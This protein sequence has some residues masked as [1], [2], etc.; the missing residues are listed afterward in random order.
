MFWKK[1]LIFFRKKIET[2]N[3]FLEFLVKI[4]SLLLK[5]WPCYLG[6]TRFGHYII[7]I[8]FICMYISKWLYS[9][10][11][12]KY[13]SL[14]NYNIWFIS[15]PVI[16]WSHGY[17]IPSWI[18]FTWMIWHICLDIFFWIVITLLTLKLNSL[19]NWL[20]MFPKIRFVSWLVITLIIQILHSLNNWLYMNFKILFN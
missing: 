1:S 8:M 19:M 14:D 7:I 4:A 13:T 5:K 16:S 18:D 17:C 15:C 6:G 12:C 20:Y 3:I 11:S 2:S 9:P 10:N